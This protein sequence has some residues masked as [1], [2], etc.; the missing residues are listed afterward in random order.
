MK[1]QT[2]LLVY[3]SKHGMTKDIVMD[4]ARKLV[5]PIHIY[6]CKAHTLLKE[7]DG[8]TV[9]VKSPSLSDYGTIIIGTPMYMGL[10]MKEIKK[11][12]IE[13]EC[14]LVHHELALFTCGIGTKEED[15]TYLRQ[16]IPYT[17]FSRYPVYGHFGAEIREAAMN[18]LER[19]AMR[20]FVKSRGV[21]PVID[22]DAIME[23]CETIN[24]NWGKLYDIRWKN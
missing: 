5:N 20:E 8:T 15:E 4:M 18:P 23:F 11:F 2:T 24:Q 12:C 22:Q 13:H 14:A 3:A 21:A 9:K 17:L 7:S 19:F 10:P 1:K 16:H 6:D